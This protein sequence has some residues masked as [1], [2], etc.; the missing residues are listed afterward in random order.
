MS[1]LLLHP[2]PL[3]FSYVGRRWISDD[4]VCHNLCDYRPPTT[5][6]QTFSAQVVCTD[7]VDC[8]QSQTLVM[9][10]TD[11]V[12]GRGRRG[13]GETA[14]LWRG[15][16][17]GGECV[18]GPEGGDAEHSPCWGRTCCHGRLVEARAPDLMRVVSVGGRGRQTL[19]AVSRWLMSAAVSPHRVHRNCGH[20]ELPLLR[21]RWKEFGEAA[22]GQSV[23]VGRKNETSSASWSHGSARCCRMSG[24]AARINKWIN[25]ILSEKNTSWVSSQK[26]LYLLFL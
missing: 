20:H 22:E 8:K 14:G 3:P 16:G 19:K 7:A 4:C 24:Q 5:S 13:R 11:G 2:T 9:T 1:Q 15:G 21:H 23:R 25:D 12:G 10:N 26:C 18:R 6:G 17:G